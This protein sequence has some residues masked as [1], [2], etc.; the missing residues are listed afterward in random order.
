M[1]DGFVVL[2]TSSVSPADV[3]RWTAS[4]LDNNRAQWRPV[5]SASLCSVVLGKEGSPPKRLNVWDSIGLRKGDRIAVHTDGPFVQKFHRLG[6][7]AEPAFPELCS[8]WE[9]QLLCRYFPAEKVLSLQ[10]S[11]QSEIYTWLCSDPLYL[12][13]Y[14]LFGIPR[15][16]YEQYEQ[17]RNDFQPAGLDYTR[18]HI[19]YAL[20]I[21]QRA[22]D[23]WRHGYT[24]NISDIRISNT[25]LKQVVQRILTRVQV[26]FSRDGWLRWPYPKQ[27]EDRA[28]ELL[29]TQPLANTPLELSAIL[30]EGPPEISNFASWLQQGGVRLIEV[31]STGFSHAAAVN[32]LQSLWQICSDA[33]IAILNCSA[34]QPL[35]EL[36]F[37]SGRFPRVLMHDT[38]LL[39]MFA[40]YQLLCEMHTDAR[41]LL[42]IL[43]FAN[44]PS[45]STSYL[46]AVRHLPR[47]TIELSYLQDA[48]PYAW[49]DFHPEEGLHS[50]ALYL[51]GQFDSA[52]VVSGMEPYRNAISWRPSADLEAVIRF[53]T[54][55]R[56]SNLS[57]WDFVFV[58][59][60]DH[61]RDRVLPQ[62]WQQIFG[63]EGVQPGARCSEAANYF[64]APGLCGP[65]PQMIS[66]GE[67]QL[68][69]TDFQ[70][71]ECLT[72][73]EMTFQAPH[74]MFYSSIP[75]TY[76]RLQKLLAL[77]ATSIVLITDRKNLKFF[78]GS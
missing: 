23:R 31:K 7:P 6:G 57:S 76:P 25:P 75:I 50:A 34:A 12:L 38:Q 46:D 49:P 40:L 8:G 20:D 69:C 74:I 71:A 13:F 37:N 58:A 32:K 52:A 16:T 44:Y 66:R 21:V 2:D 4:K 41:E 14:P 28:D 72:L 54:G 29:A 48:E 17:A 43:Y 18:E 27:I 78:A 11:K 9:S 36:H 65:D 22:N 15:L 70:Q 64:I 55:M 24:T 47:Y 1:H 68:F 67:A 63:S 60:T 26:H 5:D 56:R 33:G 30:H 51:P 39:P 61:D 53:Y 42:C 62:L 10:P 59:A 19:L 45:S 3:H 35:G 73:D 77:T